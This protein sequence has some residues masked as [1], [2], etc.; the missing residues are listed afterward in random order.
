MAVIKDGFGNEPLSIRVNARPD[1]AIEV[2]VE[3]RSKYRTMIDET[4]SYATLSE[5]IQLRNEL[6]A[7]IKE[8]VGI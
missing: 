3:H 4:L 2:W 7:V 6:N 1:S 8:A 5:I